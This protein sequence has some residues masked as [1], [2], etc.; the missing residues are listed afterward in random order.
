MVY[1]QNDF[2][3]RVMVPFDGHG[4]VWNDTGMTCVT[5]GPRFVS[6][7]PWSEW[8]NVPQTDSG[9]RVVVENND[10]AIM[11]CDFEDISYAALTFAALVDGGPITI[12]MLEALGFKWD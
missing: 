12:D 1:M 4:L 9:W 7:K 10:D 11:V 6:G 8:D 3:I 5:M 2:R